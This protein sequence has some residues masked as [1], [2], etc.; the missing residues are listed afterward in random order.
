MVWNGKLDQTEV[1]DSYKCMKC[2][3][4]WKHS[5]GFYNCSYII[6]IQLSV[7]IEVI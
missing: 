2:S 4:E 3:C 5:R 6:F 1:E 7:N